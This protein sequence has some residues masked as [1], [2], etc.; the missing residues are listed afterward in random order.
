[1]NGIKLKLT[2]VKSEEMERFDLLDWEKF[3]A[4]VK[5]TISPEDVKLISELH[6]KYFKH[7]FHIP[8]SCNPKTIVRW[9]DDLNKLYDESTL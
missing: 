2:E 7:K 3:N 5:S 4:E 6:S 1:M 9:I 8:C